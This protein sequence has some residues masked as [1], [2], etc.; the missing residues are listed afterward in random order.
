MSDFSVYRLSDR[1]ACDAKTVFLSGIQVLARLA[2]DQARS[3]RETGLRTAGMVTGYRGSPIT[4]LDREIDG[5]RDLF[6]SL[7]IRHVPA[8]NE[9]LA[10]TALWGTQQLA[11]RP[12][13]EV[14]GVFGFWYGKG[15]GLDRSMDA[16]RHA[17]AYGASSS[18]GVVLMVGDDHGASSSTVAHQSDRMLAAAHIPVLHPATLAELYGF[19]LAAMEISRR[20]GAWVALKCQTELLETSARIDLKAAQIALPDVEAS[21]AEMLFARGSEPPLEAEKRHA[22]RL[23]AVQGLVHAAALDRI[24]P[25]SETARLGIMAT[26]KA[27]LDLMAALDQ[28]GLTRDTAGIRLYKPGLVWPLEPGRAAEFAKDLDRILVVEEKGPV[29]E[30]QLR[31]ILSRRSERMPLILGKQD[32]MGAPLI[33]E[34]GVIAPDI[35]ARGITALIG[36]A[37]SPEP[38]AHEPPALPRRRPFFC[39]GCPHNT[40]TNL[41]EGSRAFAGIGCHSMAIGTG[42]A[43]DDFTQMG[44][45]GVTWQGQ[46]PFTAER[47]VFANMGDGTYY[48]SGILAIRSA[49]AAGHNITYKILFND[50]V[51]MTGGQAHDG[52]LTPLDIVRQLK[53]EGVGRTVLVS[54]EP[55]QWRAAGLPEGAELLPRDQLDPVSRELRNTPGVTAIVYDQT[56]ATE[57]RRRRKRGTAERPVTRAFINPLVCEGCGDCTRVSNCVAVEP[58]ETWQGQKRQINQSVCNID[59]SCTAGFCPSFVTVTG[60]EQ[61]T[62]TSEAVDNIL[63]KAVL[64]DPAIADDGAADILIA[65]IGGTGVLTLSAVI[66]TAAFLENRPVTLLDQ[67][68][69]AQK[70]GAVRSHIRLSR[71]T[72]RAMPSRIPKGGADLVLA[73]DAFSG[74]D[75][76][77]LAHIGRGRTQVLANATA[78]PA[79]RVS[80]GPDSRYLRRARAGDA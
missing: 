67:T 28:M 56:C 76:Q 6:S 11:Q 45:E 65:G 42:R 64:P 50:A 73:C 80:D 48:H 34:T 71:D 1:Y 63:A 26:G 18:G 38:P 54:K 22:P 36:R 35:V 58:V 23:R 25:G 41:P 16:L 62:A 49:V 27:W 15:P 14:E 69:L 10:V 32:E 20:T 30:D 7:G 79:G 33:P 60:F 55:G 29:A 77:V 4:A 31:I 78:A 46:A 59:L 21:D 57:L 39:A 3:D 74:A 44:A 24:I 43:T 9:D 13:R 61:I 72:D 19:G 2:I 66:G 52:A 5:Q 70:N 51:A 53:A 37:Q 47:H 40:S 12:E 8:L 75:P 17:A 68:G